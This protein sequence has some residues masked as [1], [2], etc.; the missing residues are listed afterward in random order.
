HAETRLGLTLLAAAGPPVDGL[1]EVARARRDAERV[2]GVLRADTRGRTGA[3]T[4]GVRS[5]VVLHG[6]KE[7]SLDHPGLTRGKLERVLAH[8]AAHTATYAETL[9]AY[10]DC[11][12]DVP[13]AAERI[14]VHPNTFR[15]RLRRLVELFDLDLDD[16][17]ERIVVELQLRLLDDD[18]TRRGGRSRRTS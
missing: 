9:R 12:G 13:R 6:L 15:Y 7:P 10:L 3:S 5:P 4:E 17:D 8:D 16:P 1:R 18:A 14:S 2:L 11:F